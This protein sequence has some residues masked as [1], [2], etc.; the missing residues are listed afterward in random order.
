MNIPKSIQFK[1]PSFEESLKYTHGYKSA[2]KVGKY[3]MNIALRFKKGHFILK[4][5]DDK[6]AALITYNEDV[7]D[8]ISGDLNEF[9]VPIIDFDKLDT[10][11]L[12]NSTYCKES[13][14]SWNLIGEPGFILNKKKFS[15]KDFIAEFYTQIFINF[16][17]HTNIRPISMCQSSMLLPYTEPDDEVLI[18][19][20]LF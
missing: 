14:S 17:C 18:F 13:D 6:S 9:N 12:Y 20:G 16:I 5:T 3:M 7:I 10:V 15:N 19:L 4:L 11:T 8:N 1:I 2:N